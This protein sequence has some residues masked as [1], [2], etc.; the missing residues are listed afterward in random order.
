MSAA[1]P[2]Q[3]APTSPSPT[4]WRVRTREL[5]LAKVLG[6]DFKPIMQM[7]YADE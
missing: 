6:D 4:L 7:V 2:A 3:A 1:R 5:R